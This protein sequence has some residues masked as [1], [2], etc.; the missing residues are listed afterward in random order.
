MA[1]E[2]FYSKFPCLGALVSV[3]FKDRQLKGRFQF[4]KRSKKVVPAAPLNIREREVPRM[5][6]PLTKRQQEPATQD[7]QLVMEHP[8]VFVAHEQNIQNGNF[9]SGTS[10]TSAYCNNF[11]TNRKSQVENFAVQDSLIHNS[12]DPD[13]VRCSADS[14]YVLH[15]SRSSVFDL[16]S[17]CSCVHEIQSSAQEESP[18]NAVFGADD[19]QW[20]IVDLHPLQT[21]WENNTI[22]QQPKEYLLQDVR[23]FESSLNVDVDLFSN[24]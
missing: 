15:A 3:F 11:P 16:K 20:H 18:P 23:G 21:D 24:S 12:Y 2:Y 8:L 22:E 7:G 4:C 10:E 19:S 14:S 1:S 6:S 17:S 9:Q 5:P 13:S